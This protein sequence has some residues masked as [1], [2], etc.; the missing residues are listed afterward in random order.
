MPNPTG[1]VLVVDAP[2]VVQRGEITKPA[3]DA[4]V[5]VFFA[6]A[7]RISAAFRNYGSAV[8]KEARLVFNAIDD[9]DADSKVLN[10]ATRTDIP[11]G[12]DLDQPFADDNLC[13]RMD[14]YSD[15]TAAAETG[16]SKLKYEGVSP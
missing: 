3:S 4:R 11:I 7:R 16:T 1:F 15:V 2:G 10:A 5:T 13:I 9:N 8:A 14:V 6:G 12:D